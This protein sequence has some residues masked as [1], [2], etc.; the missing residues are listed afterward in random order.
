MSA[1]NI[2]LIMTYEV[3]PE[4]HSAFV[5]AFNKLIVKSLTQDD[6]CMWYSMTKSTETENTFKLIER[7]RDQASLD[8]HSTSP[9][10]D[11]Y[12][13]EIGPLVGTAHKEILTA[14]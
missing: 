7:W 14:V 2:Y 9:S 1:E 5:T 12:R 6:G 4:N 13:A 8:A 11:P 10:M 3:A